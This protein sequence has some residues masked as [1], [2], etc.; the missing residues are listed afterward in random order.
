MSP[1]L[2]TH[3]PIIG[4]NDSQVKDWSEVFLVLYED[5]LALDLSDIGQFNK[6]QISDISDISALKGL[7]L[8]ELNINKSQISDI[9]A[10]KGM[11][12]KY[13]HLSHTNVKDIK[14]LKGMHLVNLDLS[15]TKVNDISVLKGMPL[16]TLD[17][18]VKDVSDISVLKGM[19]LEHLFLFETN[20]TDVKPLEGMPLKSLGMPNDTIISKHLLKCLMFIGLCLEKSFKIDCPDEEAFSI[21]LRLKQFHNIE[22]LRDIRTL[23]LI[24]IMD[25][26]AVWKAYDILNWTKRT[27]AILL[28]LMSCG[29]IYVLSRKKKTKGPDQQ[30]KAKT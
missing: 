23:E 8:V 13:L 26:P 20:I 25:P 5:G 29:L 14:V 6:S 15:Y 2:K 19:Q 12:L 10:L 30:E 11:P 4:K 17:L 16:E 9:S 28:V 21:M 24:N 1:A 18:S 3:S 22:V 7:P 27:I